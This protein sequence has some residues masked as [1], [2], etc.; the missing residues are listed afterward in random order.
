MSLDC[1]ETELNSAGSWGEKGLGTK[2]AMNPLGGLSEML[3]EPVEEEVTTDWPCGES[4]AFLSDLWTGAHFPCFSIGQPQPPT[5]VESQFCKVG[6]LEVWQPALRA[7]GLWGG[8]LSP[9]LI[10]AWYYGQMAPGVGGR[11]R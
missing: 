9:R 8:F 2:A 3:I 10:A 6:G 7:A 5:L 1:R 11:S 4:Q